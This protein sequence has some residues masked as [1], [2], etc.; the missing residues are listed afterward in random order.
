MKYIQKRKGV[1]V[2]ES[3]LKYIDINHK[4]FAICKQFQ[5]GK[6]TVKAINEKGSY[7]SVIAVCRTKKVAKEIIEQDLKGVVSELQRS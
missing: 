2:Y 3:L 7:E 6:Y 1:R 4:L 5:P